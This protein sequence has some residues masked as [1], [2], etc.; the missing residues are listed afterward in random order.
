VL[1]EQCRSARQRGSG[2]KANGEKL[3]HSGRKG[4]RR[5][6]LAGGGT[7]PAGSMVC[8]EHVLWKKMGEVV[9]REDK[10]GWSIFPCVCGSDPN[11]GKTCIEY[12]SIIN[13]RIV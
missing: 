10:V 2:I 8:I 5:G 7:R 6:G 11:I 4:R 12:Y 13:Y 3:G 9:H 1:V